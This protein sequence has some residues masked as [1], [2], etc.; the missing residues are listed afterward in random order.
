MIDIP[1]R[2]AQLEARLADLGARLEGIEA[3]LDSHNSRDLEEL[4][5]ERETEEVLES[6]G[7]SGQQEIRAIT[8]ALARIDADEYGY[9]VK[10]GAEI[11]EARLDV[12]PYTPFC[13]KCAG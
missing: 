2:K 5:T 7:T 10:C 12:L 8:A 13:R 3:E 11:G 6:M 9:C 4:A 1:R